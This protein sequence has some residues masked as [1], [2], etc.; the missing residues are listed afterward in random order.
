MQVK[1]MDSELNRPL[2]HLYNKRDRTNSGNGTDRHSGT[3]E[4]YLT[5]AGYLLLIREVRCGILLLSEG[6]ALHCPTQ[7]LRLAG[8]PNKANCADY[9][10]PSNST[11]HRFPMLLGVL[12]VR[13]WFDWPAENIFSQSPIP[14]SAVRQHRKQSRFYAQE[15]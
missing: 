5:F 11:G 12:P 3:R 6:C 15:T 9:P 14:Y 8:R 1:L 2:E 4:N 13:N 7:E 10:D